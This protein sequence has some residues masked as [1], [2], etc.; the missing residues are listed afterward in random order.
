MVAATI[1]GSATL[2]LAPTLLH[3]SRRAADPTT[4]SAA[5]LSICGWTGLLR[6]QCCVRHQ[7]HHLGVPDEICKAGLRA[8]NAEGR[9]GFT[10]T[11]EAFD[12]FTFYL[13]APAPEEGFDVVVHRPES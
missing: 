9:H 11:D 8:R 7:L 2:G 5:L 1:I 10:V 4:A 12:L 3:V 13:V 6:L